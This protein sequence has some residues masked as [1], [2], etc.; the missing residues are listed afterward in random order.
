[1]ADKS[2]ADLPD[3]FRDRTVQAVRFADHDAA[4]P[5]HWHQ[6]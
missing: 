3:A 4:N 5:Y 1:M 6:V 2:I